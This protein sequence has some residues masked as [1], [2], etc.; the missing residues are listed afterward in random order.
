MISTWRHRDVDSPPVGRIDNGTK[1]TFPHE[2]TR[3]KQLDNYSIIPKN[4][5]P[6]TLGHQSKHWHSSL[7]A[8]GKA[9][10][11]VLP[12]VGPRSPALRFKPWVVYMLSDPRPPFRIE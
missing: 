11:V 3:F 2:L 9:S 1:T 5:H 7:Q 4:S 8:T 6:G 10:S 12:E